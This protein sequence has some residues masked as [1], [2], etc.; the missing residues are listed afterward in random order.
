MYGFH[1][2]KL[3]KQSNQCHHEKLI[4]DKTTCS[5]ITKSYT[6]DCIT[7]IYSQS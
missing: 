2:V 7:W 1:M 3:Y 6:L 5:G 4:G